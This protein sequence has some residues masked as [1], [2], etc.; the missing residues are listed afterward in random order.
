MLTAIPVISRVLDCAGENIVEIEDMENSKC[1]SVVIPTYNEER[2]VGRVIDEVRKFAPENL[3]IIV[4]DG[5]SD[6]RTVEVA[7]SKRV[8]VVELHRLGKGLASRTGAEEAR[9]NVLVFM[10]GD[11]TYPPKSIPSLIEPILEGKFDLVRGSRF[12]GEPERMDSVRY[13]GNRIFTSLA[14]MLYGKTTDLL[15][16]MYAIRKDKLLNLDMKSLGFTFETELFVKARG[17][18]LK[19]KEVPISYKA[20]YR[21]KLHPIKDGF[22]ILLELL[23]LR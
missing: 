6:D 1:V 3:E 15:T 23:R 10:D 5:G 8:K 22:K 7:E 16:G 21:S 18:N 17:L 9:G 19:E 11:R 20:G 14:S 4:V 13:F 2:F 12:L